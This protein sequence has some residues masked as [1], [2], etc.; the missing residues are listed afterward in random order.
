HSK[1]DA[2]HSR[3]DAPQTV[4]QATLSG[5]L[6]DQCA[7]VEPRGACP[8]VTAGCRC[9]KKAEIVAS[10]FARR[11]KFKD[12]VHTLSWTH[13]LPDP[14]PS[15]NPPPLLD[16]YGRSRCSFLTRVRERKPGLRPGILDQE[17]GDSRRAS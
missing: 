6:D 5:R 1:G 16:T 12:P 8:V 15:G 13:V 11:L 7:S 3:S 9:E 2:N 4:S 10:R 17:A 14:D